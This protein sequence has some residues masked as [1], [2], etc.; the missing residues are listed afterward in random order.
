MQDIQKTVG[1]RIRE[2]RLKHGWSQDVFADKSGLHRAHVG[3]IER[4]ERNVTPHGDYTACGSGRIDSDDH[5]TCRTLV[6]RDDEALH[7]HTGEGEDGCC[8]RALRFSCSDIFA[9]LRRNRK[10]TVLNYVHTNVHMTVNHLGKNAV[11][12]SNSPG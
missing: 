3:A 12:L 4:G 5:G 9:G 11:S 2:L 1:A 10:T 7:A 6:T 8:G